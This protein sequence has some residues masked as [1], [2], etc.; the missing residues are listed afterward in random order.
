MLTELS[1]A[2]FTNELL[3]T[4][5]VGGLLGGDLGV[6]DG[7]GGW[8]GFGDVAGIG[9]GWAGAALD[10]LCAD[11]TELALLWFGLLVV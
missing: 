1:G 4:T 9:G 8:L 2:G 5:Q 7:L 10:L 11:Y 3:G 6:E